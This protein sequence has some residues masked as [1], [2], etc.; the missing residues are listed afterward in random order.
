MVAEKND[1]FGEAWRAMYAQ[2]FLANQALVASFFQSFVAAASG[3]K[4][5]AARSAARFQK[6]ALGIA[7]KGLAPVHRK[8]TA[9]A[10][11][12]ARTKLR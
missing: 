2:A 7:G 5:S 4:P 6:A 11:R 10:K 12:L 9:N 8:A 3:K 1:A